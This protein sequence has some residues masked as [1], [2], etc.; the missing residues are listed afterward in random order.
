MKS[1]VIH[2]TNEGAGFDEALAQAEAVARFRD[3]DR[4]SVLHLRLLTEEMMGMMRALTGEREADFWI[5]DGEG[6]FELHLQVKTPMN[7]EM[8][9]KLLAASSSG[10][11]TAAKGV[12]GKIRDLFERFLEPENGTIPGALVS[13][14]VYAYS[15][16]D[17]GTLSVA[18]AGLWSMN[19]YKAAVKEGR[20]PEEDW[21]ELEKSI[22][23][24][25][26]DDVQ[27]GIAGQN[28]E[29]II[30]KKF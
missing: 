11:N 9:K 10:E 8:R 13:G 21:D 26:A 19:R 28:V 1:D 25:I 6:S 18:A 16:A 29:M 23:A 2:V 20:A 22:V 24:N 7:A 4:K 27:I 12:T 15:G 3:L 5:D 14:M 30:F 17:L